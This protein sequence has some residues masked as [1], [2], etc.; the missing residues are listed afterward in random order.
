M[1]RSEG[2]KKLHHQNWD[3]IIIGGGATGLGISL[4]SATRGYQTLLLESKDFSQGTSSRSTKLLHGG[5]RYLAQGNFSLVYEALHERSRLIQ[6]APHLCSPQSFIVPSY[7]LWDTLYYGV[8]L[9]VYA[10]MAG[11]L[12]LKNTEILSKQE[13]KT[14]LKGIQDKKLQYGIC[15]YDGQFDDARLCITL[16]QSAI[17]HG[18]TLLNYAEVIELLHDNSGHI[19][20]VVIKDHIHQKY[21]KIQ[22]KCIINATGVF[23]NTIN[24]LDSSTQENHIMPSQGIHLVFD[25]KFLPSLD[26]LMVPKTSDGRVLFAIPWHNKLIVG[27]TDTPVQNICYDPLPLDEEIDF[28]LQT[29]GEYLTLKPTKKDILSYFVGLRPLIAPSQSQ[30][31]KDVSRSHKIYISPRKLVHINGGKWTTYRHMAEETLNACIAEKLL[32][33]S[34]SVTKDLKLY[35]YC[36]EYTLEH[37]KVYGTEASAIEELEKNNSKFAQKIHPNYPYTFAQ[38]FWALEHEMAQTLEDVLSRRIRLLFLDAQAAYECAQEVGEFIGEYLAWD[39]DKT[40]HS[41]KNF[42]EFAKSHIFNKE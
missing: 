17:Y 41:I 18:A 13:V 4:D 2:I 31:S 42:Q 12:N 3:V 8:G 36:T 26:A 15:Y 5:V 40:L 30:K 38:V 20:G 9:K 25:S 7:N 32:P 10:L 28:L 22:A 19:K 37:L 14:R 1:K 35:G 29:L 11:K 39:K 34:Y 16:A 27:T 33:P 21:Y 6:N 24:S 23:T